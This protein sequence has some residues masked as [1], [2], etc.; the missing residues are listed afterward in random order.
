MAKTS[1]MQQDRLRDYYLWP[2]MDVIA[3]VGFLAPF[4]PALVKLGESAA[5]SVSGM[6]MF[7]RKAKTIWSELWL[8]LE[9]KHLAQRVV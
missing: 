3:L 9:A 6:K 4:L 7:G 5:I 8:K 1:S 2:P